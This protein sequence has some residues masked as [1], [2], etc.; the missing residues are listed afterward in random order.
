MNG[1]IGPGLPP[2]IT[3]LTLLRGL[4]PR[5]FLLIVFFLRNLLPVTSWQADSRSACRTSTF[6]S[7]QHLLLE[8]RIANLFFLEENLES[9][10]ASNRAVLRSSASLSSLLY[11]TEPLPNMS[12]NPTKI[13]DAWDDDWEKLA[14]VGY[15]HLNSGNLMSHNGRGK[16]K[17][18]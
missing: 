3:K 4:K 1:M 16:R 7:L 11:P 8:Y 9:A 13:P 10:I 14:D 12:S 2:H 18:N 6:R 15:L 5:L 17:K